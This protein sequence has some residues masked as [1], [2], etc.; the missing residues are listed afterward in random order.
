MM[1]VSRVT[2]GQITALCS[3][4]SIWRDLPS[5]SLRRAKQFPR[6]FLCQ[7]F[8]PFLAHSSPSPLIATVGDSQ[9]PLPSQLWKHLFQQLASDTHLS[10]DFF[11]NLLFPFFFLFSFTHSCY[12]LSL[13]VQAFSVC[14]AIAGGHQVPCRPSCLS[15]CL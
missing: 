1:S 5:P 13:L 11:W 12:V 9:Q 15:L 3:P 10:N 2:V 6:Y 8:D 7:W 14:S 4:G